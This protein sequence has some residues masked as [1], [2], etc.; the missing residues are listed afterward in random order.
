MRSSLVEHDGRVP[1]PLAFW[2]LVLLSCSL[3]AGWAA[4]ARRPL[5]RL[6]APMQEAEDLLRKGVTGQETQRVQ[7]EIVNR[8]D[9]LIAAGQRSRGFAVSVPGKEAEPKQ[10][11]PGGR[12]GAPDKPAD[13]SILS[14]GRW[15]YGLLREPAEL[16]DAWMPELPSTERKVVADTFRTGRLPPRY[17]ELLRQ[18]NKR[19]AEA[20]RSEE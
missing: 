8:L 4:T 18:Y 20:G 13:E 14:A 5:D 1:G 11:A 19:L 16:E 17:R 12:T 15:G 10:L 2:V 6:S 7:Q 3:A 9:A